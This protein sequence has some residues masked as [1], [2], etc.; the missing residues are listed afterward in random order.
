[1]TIPIERT[2]AIK[3]AREFLRD[4]LD[5]KKTPKVSSKIRKRAL[6]VLRHFP[7]DYDLNRLSKRSSDILGWDPE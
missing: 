6:A 2:N 7:G 4:L 3:Y 1:M 5:P